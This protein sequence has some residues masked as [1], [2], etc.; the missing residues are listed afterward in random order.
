MVYDYYTQYDDNGRMIKFID[1]SN[2]QLGQ[3][4]KYGEEGASNRKYRQQEDQDDR[5]AKFGTILFGTDP[6]KYAEEAGHGAVL[7][8]KYNYDDGDSSEDGDESG[9]SGGTSTDSNTGTGFLK[10]ITDPFGKDYSFQRLENGS[11]TLYPNNTFTDRTYDQWG[12]LE[13]IAHKRRETGGAPAGN[14]DSGSSSGSGD[15]SGEFGSE[16]LLQSFTYQYDN[17]GNITKITEANGEYIDY[18]YGPILYPPMNTGTDAHINAIRGLSESDIFAVGQNGTILHYDGSSWSSM[19]SGTT[20]SLNG[21]FIYDSDDVYAV[22]DNG[23]IL[24]YDGSAWSSMTSGTTQNLNAVS[25]YHYSSYWGVRAVG[26]NGTILYYYG[27][28]WQALDSGIT[29]NLN[30]V[31]AYFNKFYIV[32]DNGKIYKYTGTW[33]QMESG[34]TEDL[35]AIW[36]NNDEDDYIYAVGKNGTILKHSAAWSQME[37]GTDKDLYDVWGV[38]E[39][40]SDFLFA[41]GENGALL[42]CRYSTWQEKNTGWREDYRCIWIPSKSEAYMGGMN[43]ILIDYTGTP[44]ATGSL[45]R[46]LQEHRK[47]SAGD[48]IYKIEYTFDDN[49]SK[50]GNIHRVVYDGK[51]VTEFTY[52][53]MNELTGITHPDTS[54]ETLTYDNNGNLTQTVNNTTG[55]T[56]TYEWDCFD[57]L[58]KVTLPAKNGGASG[59]IVEFEYDED[60]MLVGEKSAGMERKFTQQNRFA[61]R[62]LV[63][64]RNG[65]WEMSAYHTIHG[66]MLATHIS[67]NSKKAGMNKVSNE[68]GTIFYHTD[69][70]GSVRL[71]TDSHGNVVSSST[72]DAYGNPLPGADSLGNNGAKMLSEFNFIGTYGIRYV[73]K[74]KLHNMRYRFYSPIFNRFL[75]VDRMKENLNFYSYVSGK[76]INFYDPYGDK[77]VSYS[78]KPKYTPQN[79]EDISYIHTLININKV[80]IQSL[81]KQAVSWDKIPP[82]SALLSD[83]F[84]LCQ[85]R[86]ESDFKWSVSSGTCGKGGKISYKNYGLMQIRSQ[87][88]NADVFHEIPRVDKMYNQDINDALPKAIIPWEPSRA[89]SEIGLNIATGVWQLYHLG[90]LELYGTSAGAPWIKDEINSC[91][92]CINALFKKNKSLTKDNK[93]NLQVLMRRLTAKQIECELKKCIYPSSK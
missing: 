21:V 47:T 92:D 32:G 19:A 8:T 52:N 50:N 6:I 67:S 85:I 31:L 14:G 48:T 2:A 90:S 22:G 93:V 77:E 88:N 24:H 78:W 36:G 25:G 76:V 82:I 27:N 42:Q 58:M 62:E 23:T 44:A 3:N 60:G 4:F 16:T 54:T 18:Y 53:E 9:T 45:N 12:R 65:E 35:L 17:S 41:A 55:E 56:T 1:A 79:N 81:Y 71:I 70:L 30:G 37:S 38:S 40:S 13:T 87:S 75:S 91:S 89:K 15:G 43:G 34:T 83:A 33:T 84:F 28:T 64:N 11:R 26:D 61:T 7:S 51:H 39:G 29:E 49:S 69:H 20:Q 63:K 86:H 73:E 10:S 80:N 46:L 72:T 68:T 74:I 59:E 57:R 5:V 66:Q